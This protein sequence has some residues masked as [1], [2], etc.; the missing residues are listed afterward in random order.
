MSGRLHA[1]TGEGWDGVLMPGEEILWQGRPDAAFQFGAAQFAT[2]LF[3]LFFAGFATVWMLLASTGGGYFWT[4][5][6]IHFSVGI[7]LA[8]GAFVYA[9]WR[10]RHTWY[11]LTN[12][13]AFIATDL[14]FA[15]RK[16]RSWPIDADTGISHDG[17]DPATVHFAQEF[18][19]TK[20]GTRTVPIGFERISEGELVHRMMAGI[21]D[22]RRAAET[23]M[24]VQE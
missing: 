16:L 20:N 5:G 10:R 9:P 6:L 15:G 18:I 24:E 12:R 14:P 3:G 2:A 7:G 22:R 13:R 4:F 8:I 1:H 23:T 11:T 19:Q 21:R 17:G